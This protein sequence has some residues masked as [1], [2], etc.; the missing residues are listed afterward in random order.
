MPTVRHLKLLYGAASV[1][2]LGFV[3]VKLFFL[4]PADHNPNP[5]AAV[6]CLLLI[7]LLPVLGGYFLLFKVFAWV[8]RSLRRPKPHEHGGQ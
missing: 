5:L 8:G 4:L 3:V 1:I 6:Y 2:W 7:G